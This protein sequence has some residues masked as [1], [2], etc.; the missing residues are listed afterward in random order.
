VVEMVEMPLCSNIF[1]G[2]RVSWQL[3]FPSKHPAPQV[4]VASYFVSHL[5]NAGG[6]ALEPGTV[7]KF[8]ERARHH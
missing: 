6:G 1:L 2:E 3:P 7:A 8:R 5:E 4:T